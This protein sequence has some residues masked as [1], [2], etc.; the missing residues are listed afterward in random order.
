MAS[1]LAAV[2]LGGIGLLFPWLR[3]YW[4]A[5]FNGQDADLPGAMLVRAPLQGACLWGANLSGAK[6]MG[7]SLAGAELSDTNL[8]G[9]DLSGASLAG[10]TVVGATG[11]SSAN[12][13]CP[14]QTWTV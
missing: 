9:A 3:V 5:K 6:L 13:L 1:V 11:L 12:L 2:L 10:A 4:V 7:A 14:A 8:A